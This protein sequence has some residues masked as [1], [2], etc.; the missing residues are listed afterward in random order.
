M[1]YIKNT[2]RQLFCQQTPKPQEK[3]KSAELIRSI[4]KALENDNVNVIENLVL[5]GVSPN[6]IAARFRTLENTITFPEGSIRW[7]I[8]HGY[9]VDERGRTYPGEYN[10]CTQTRSA[11]ERMVDQVFTEER[12]LAG[13][14]LHNNSNLINFLNNLSDEQITEMLPLLK[15]IFLL[16][17]AHGQAEAVGS[18]YAR[19]HRYFEQNLL[20]E[21]FIRATLAGQASVSDLLRT[22]LVPLGSDILNRAFAQAVLHGRAKIVEAILVDEQVNLSLHV[23]AALEQLQSTLSERE[24]SRI[25]TPI[26]EVRRS[27]QTG[28]STIRP[29]VWAEQESYET[30]R[31]LLHNALLLRQ[32]RFQP[33]YK[34]DFPVEIAEHIR[35]FI[36]E[37]A[38]LPTG[39]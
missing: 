26:Q 33:L 18:L 23:L 19:A 36:P 16:A 34:L 17:A 37:M 22:Y 2:W 12:F 7:I 13:I 39:K 25:I 1:E 15:D 21:A 38:S 6:V 31:E 20:E 27:R 30:I 14:A 5:N 4:D 35:S 11:Y 8:E 3:Q 29:D 24:L 28:I 32:I 10:A 9:Y